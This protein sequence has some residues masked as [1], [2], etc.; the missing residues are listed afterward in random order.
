MKDPGIFFFVPLQ[1]FIIGH[2]HFYPGYCDRGIPHTGSGLI[3][4]R[5]VI[6]Q[7]LNKLNQS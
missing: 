3:D 7:S 6:Q 1:V 2:F 4:N 5:W